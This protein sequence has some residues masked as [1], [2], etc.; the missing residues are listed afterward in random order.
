MPGMH[1]QALQH[2]GAGASATKSHGATKVTAHT[3]S[4]PANPFNEQA[5]QPQAGQLHLNGPPGRVP[6]LEFQDPADFGR[7]PNI[8]A[9]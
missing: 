5:A 3:G 4:G 1:V 8:S 9:N 6:G 7:T 2:P